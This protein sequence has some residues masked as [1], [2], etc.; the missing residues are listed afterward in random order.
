MDDERGPDEV[1]RGDRRRFL[2]KAGA[3]GAAAWVAPVVLSSPAFA[4]QSGPPPT[5]PPPACIPCNSHNVVNGSF[6]DATSRPFEG[7]NLFPGWQLV[8]DPVL[9]QFLYTDLEGFVPPFVPPTVPHGDHCAG[10]LAGGV[11][12]TIPIDRACVGKP[13]TLSFWS[14]G[15]GT[16]FPTFGNGILNYGFDGAAGSTQVDL[17]SSMS[18]TFTLQSFTGVVPADATAFTVSFHGFALE[19]DLVDLT[20]CS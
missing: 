18:S 13:F 20:I 17:T 11:T 8:A 2:I 10:M 3:A 7:G 16:S 19:I 5:Q 4:A 15:G 14:A 12:Q 6:E 9:L 1:E